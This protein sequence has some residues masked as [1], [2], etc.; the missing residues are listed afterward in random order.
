MSEARESADRPTPK[1]QPF[2]PLEREVSAMLADWEESGE[3]HGPFARR[4]I[5]VIRLGEENGHKIGQEHR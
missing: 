4:L 5:A 3:L 1:Q 2:T